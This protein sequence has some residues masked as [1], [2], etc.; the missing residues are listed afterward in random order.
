M[1]NA[2]DWQGPVGSVWADEWERTDR[3]FAGLSV[4]LDA[5]ILAAAP[6]APATALDIGCGAG[7]TSI[8]LAMARPDVAVIGA[9]IAPDLI[10]VARTR[11]ADLPNAGFMVADLNTGLPDPPPPGSPLFDRLPFDLIMSRHGL[12]FFDDPA[13]VFASI[14]GVAAPEASLVFSCFRSSALNPWAVDLAAAVTGARPSSPSGY[15][16][17]PFA[18]ADPG[19]VETLLADAGWRDVMREPID[20]RYVAGAGESAVADAVAFFCRVGPVASALKA[21]PDA[22]RP[23]SLDKLAATLHDCCDNDEVAFPAAAWIWRARA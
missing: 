8:A 3:S 20:Y 12:M 15:A 1:T 9:D 7:A 6:A 16:A 13:A 4:H 22:A 5:A 10:A 23:G 11:G 19:F 14:H 2:R 21:L 17:G 18:F